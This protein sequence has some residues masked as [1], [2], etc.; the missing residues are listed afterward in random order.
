MAALRLNAS[1]A[2]EMTSSAVSS[3]RRP[4]PRAGG[5][6]AGWPAA[7]TADSPAAGRLAISN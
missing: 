1:A 4:D 5:P 6:V 2:I 3:D 7:G